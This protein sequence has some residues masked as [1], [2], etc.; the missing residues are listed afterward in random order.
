M[1]I[2]V[3]KL[4]DS[5]TRSLRTQSNTNNIPYAT[6]SARE[7]ITPQYQTSVESTGKE[8]NNWVGDHEAQR[9][10]HRPSTRKE[11]VS[12]VVSMAGGKIRAV[13]SGHSHSN[14]PEAP[15]HYIDLNPGG[16]DEGPA[17]NKGLNKLLDHRGWLKNSANT[18]Y[19]RR[20]ES[21]VM[22]RRLNRY[23]LRNTDLGKNGFALKNMGS[24]DGQTIAGAVNTSTHGTGVGLSSIA[25]SVKSVEIA[26]VPES[27][28]G[29]PIVRLYRIEPDDGITD[30]EAFEQAVDTHE[31]ELIQD[32]DIFRSVVVG[33]GS[34][35][36]VYA[37]TLEVIDNYWLKEETEL[38]DWKTLKSKLGRSKGS[39]KQ[40]LNKTDSQGRQCRHTMILLNLAA[41][42][43]PKGKIQT[44]EAHGSGQ[45]EAWH[46]PLCLV[47]RHYKVTNFPTEK[48]LTWGAGF[49]DDRWP[50]ERRKKTWKD[51]GQAIFNQFHPL[52]PNEARAKQLHKQF[53]H[54][55][56]QKKPFVV[57]RNKTV[58]YIALRRIR[59]R[60]GTNT[61]QY[62]HPKPPQP[63]PTTEM[64]VPLGD[65][66]RAV[67]SVRTRVRSVTQGSQVPADQKNATGEGRDVFF[68]APMGIRFTAP[69]EHYLSPEHG[70]TTAMVEVPLPVNNENKETNAFWRGKV[71]ALT[72]D[73]MRDWV[74]EPALTKIHDHLRNEF[75]TDPKTA[76]KPHMGKH[77]TLGAEDLDEI[78][79][80]FDASGT[81]AE[82]GW[83]QAYQ[84]F[85]AFGTFDNKFTNE[86]LGLGNFTPDSD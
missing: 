13:G 74:V 53:F 47:R 17:P 40:F 33:Y 50:P 25:D 48:P 65:V 69:S 60:G 82:T 34:M 24:F 5:G 15:E 73:Q 1:T 39:V 66:V 4:L 63:T 62:Y 84:R 2:S 85:N 21:G 78:Y 18:P 31:M 86:Q 49:S 11:L 77:N 35:G 26:T 41:D 71:P 37:Y 72:Q 59:D 23:L 56:S 67:D 46:N 8:W 57:N 42:Q 70:R 58:W 75:G 30:R 61:S 54:P 52:K 64:A 79:E 43:V 20:L 36:V 9:T 45:H 38:M 16:P 81:D 28:S 22:L 51:I 7:L 27:A 12:A 80:Y 29:D 44:H 19:L 55:A 83:Y 76:A 32:D 14:A 10:V 68:G 6:F 3:R